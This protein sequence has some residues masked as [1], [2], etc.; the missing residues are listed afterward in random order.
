M[1]P[2][3][4]APVKHFCVLAGSRVEQ[5]M[6]T[7]FDLLAFGPRAGLGALLSMPE[8]LQTLQSDV[9]RVSQLVQDPR[10]VEEKQQLVMQEVEDTLVTFLERGATVETDILANIKV[11]LP[12]DV[13]KQLDELIPPPP[14]SQPTEVVVEPEEMP[15]VIYTADA[16]LEN[17]IASEMTEVK[18]AVSGVK[19]ALE[20]LRA[21]ADPSRA[22]M[23]KLNLR[24]ARDILARR[25]QETAPGVAPEGTSAD[26]SLAAA[27]REASVLLDEVDAQFFSI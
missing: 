21:N 15:T 24:E 7:P 4:R 27:T 5:W 13:T 16:V 10:S 25:L 26:G 8:R 17:Q 19:A 1:Q 22:A 18:S 23:L 9:E 20:D 11:L 3:Q 2:H 6:R 14:N 12:P